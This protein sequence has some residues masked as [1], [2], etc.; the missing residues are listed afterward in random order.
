VLAA[1]SPKPSRMA[2]VP[3]SKSQ[4]SKSSKNVK[5]TQSD[6]IVVQPSK[7]RKGGM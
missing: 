7:P 3:D 1:A 5:A 4:G 6:D 2:P